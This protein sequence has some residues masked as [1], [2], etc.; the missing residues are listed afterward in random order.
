MGEIVGILSCFVL[1]LRLVDWLFGGEF[2]STV[3]QSVYLG[4][5]ESEAKLVKA[6]QS[7]SKRQ[8]TSQRATKQTKAT[9]NSH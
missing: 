3:S 7:K 4:D 1:E 2:K 6:S 8:K 9:T 5:L